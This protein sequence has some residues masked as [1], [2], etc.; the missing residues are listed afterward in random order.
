[1]VYRD[2]GSFRAKSQG[3]D[4]ITKRAVKGHT[5]VIKDILRNK[6]ISSKRATRKRVYVVANKIFKAGEVLLAHIQRI[7][8]KILCTIF[9]YNLYQLMAL[10]ING[11]S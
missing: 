3:Y 7:S 8:L 9:Y 6:R 2:R 10:D 5:L 4:A 11:L 1:V